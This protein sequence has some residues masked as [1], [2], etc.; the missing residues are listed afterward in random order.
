MF[1]PDWNRMF[2]RVVRDLAPPDFPTIVCLCGSGRFTEAFERAEFDE[3]LKGKIVQT[4]G[5]NTKDVART[6]DLE[7]HK[8]MLD[9]LHKRKIELADSILVLNVGGYIGES[10]RSEIAHAIRMGKTVCYLEPVGE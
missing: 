1:S 2:A 7:H 4:I 8:P 3:T 5:C 9:E 10:T 6:P